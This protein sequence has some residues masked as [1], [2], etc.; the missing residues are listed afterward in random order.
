MEGQLGDVPAGEP[1]GNGRS[2]R[3]FG[4]YRRHRGSIVWPLILI[5][6][7]IIFLLNNTGA[8]SWD[9]WWNLARLWPLLLIA[10][11]LD[12]LI[13]RRSLLGSVLVAVVILGAM[14]AAVVYWKPGSGS[15]AGL[16]TTA[17]SQGLEGASRANV[18]I[19]V[20]TANLSI[21]EGA[22]GAGLVQGSVML[23]NNERLSSPQFTR[24]GDNATYRLQV[25]GG[26]NVWPS[27]FNGAG[28]NNK[29]WDLQF[30]PDVPMSF[31]IDG[32]VGNANIDLSRFKITGLDVNAGVGNVDV[33]L[34]RAG[35]F[36]TAVDAGIGRVH[37]IIPAGMAARVNVDGGLGGVEIKGDLQRQGEN[38]YLTPGYDTASNRADIKVNGGIGH[39]IVEQQ[40]GG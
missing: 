36:S 33:T 26:A 40:T 22:E 17:I 1:F 30:N 31:K 8:I 20:G 10:V 14:A 16:T 19:R 9:I 15:A 34:P 29:R 3:H 38:R 39:I 35:Q 7:G 18:D 2:E 13:G 5:G 6:A 27:G 4:E 11:G 21:K 37:I 28:V 25:N 23:S 32:G 12:I 24:N